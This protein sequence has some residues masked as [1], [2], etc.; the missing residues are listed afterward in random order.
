MTRALPGTAGL[1]SSAL[2]TPIAGRPAE[3]RELFDDTHLS[4][5]WNDAERSRAA[6]V[7]VRV[8]ALVRQIRRAVINRISAQADAGIG[9]DAI[10]K[11]GTPDVP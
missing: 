11:A 1:D 5:V 2:T 8:D 3:R 6:F 10:R 7:R 9:P 4:D